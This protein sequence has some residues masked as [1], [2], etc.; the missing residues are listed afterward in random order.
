MYILLIYFSIDCWLLNLR[1]GLLKKEQDSAGGGIRRGRGGGGGYL[2]LTTP[3][4]HS[5]N[6]RAQQPTKWYK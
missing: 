5:S 2:Y 1:V 4:V 3:K 6:K